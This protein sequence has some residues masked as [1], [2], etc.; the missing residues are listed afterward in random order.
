MGGSIVTWF[1]GARLDILMSENEKL[2]SELDTKETRLQTLEDSLASE[3]QYIVQDLEII[4]EFEEGEEEDELVKLTLEKKIRTMLDDIWGK[5]VQSLDPLLIAN[6][7][8]RRTLTVEE[9]TYILTVTRGPLVSEKVL[10][11]I[12]ASRKSDSENDD[13]DN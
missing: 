13:Y 5:D 7:I 9:Q 8:E 11:Y 4:V 6:I 3:H 1:I 10:I 12:K 2:A